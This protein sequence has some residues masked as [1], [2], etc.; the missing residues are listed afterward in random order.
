MHVFNLL[1]ILL[2][3][4]LPPNTGQSSLGPTAGSLDHFLMAMFSKVPPSANCT[5]TR[6]L[7]S[8]GKL[9]PSTF[10]WTL[11]MTSECLYLTS[12]SPDST[13][14][15]LIVCWTPLSGCSWASQNQ[16]VQKG[17]PDLPSESS[18]I[19][20]TSPKTC[21]HVVTQARGIRAMIDLSV[22][23]APYP[24]NY[25]RALN[26]FLSCLFHDLVQD[27]APHWSCCCHSWVS[28]SPFCRH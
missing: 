27:Q 7:W 14:N 8:Q 11:M 22:S 19:P 4:R 15:Y 9:I 18:S 21:V 23:P 5:F 2:P 17:T 3:S 12:P 26:S 20:C 25:Q 16:C 10:T 28:L 13:L 6:S 1:Q 24:I